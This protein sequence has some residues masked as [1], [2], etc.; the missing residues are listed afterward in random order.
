MNPDNIVKIDIMELSCNLAHNA[1]KDEMFADNLIANEDEMVIGD[2]TL[3]YTDEAQVIFNRWYDY[4]FDEI[5]KICDPK[6]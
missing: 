5:N 3:N 4:F 2:D 6:K 1:A